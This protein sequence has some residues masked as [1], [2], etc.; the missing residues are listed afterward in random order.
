MEISKVD[1][2]TGKYDAEKAKLQKELERDREQF[3]KEWDT[4][5]NTRPSI[6]EKTI[7]D[8]IRS[9]LQHSYMINALK[10]CGPS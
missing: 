10:A 4:E 6:E 2:T 5:R 1:P 8:K 7:T 3:A 9:E